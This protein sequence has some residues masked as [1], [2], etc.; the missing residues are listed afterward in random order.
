MTGDYWR[1][2][3]IFIH[4]SMQS[5]WP[6]VWVCVWVSVCVSTWENSLVTILK[7]CCSILK[8]FL[9]CYFVSDHLNFKFVN[10]FC[11]SPAKQLSGPL[12]ILPS[13]LNGHFGPGSTDSL[14]CF[15]SC[16]SIWIKEPAKYINEWLVWQ[17]LC[18]E[19]R[20]AQPMWLGICQCLFVLLPKRSR[21]LWR[22]ILHS[23]ASR[24]PK[25][26]E[27]IGFI[28]QNSL[29]WGVG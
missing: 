6:I 26:T 21:Y 5:L 25:W 2:C 29:P 16:M 23:R 22:P 12:G 8:F 28:A 9:F 18:G 14:H 19:Y 13:L 20:C 7:H 17:H 1:T 15:L 11:Y 27:M 10:L 24:G 3:C 4:F